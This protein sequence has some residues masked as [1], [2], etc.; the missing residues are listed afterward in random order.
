MKK[1]PANLDVKPHQ[2]LFQEDSKTSRPIFPPPASGNILALN[3]AAADAPKGVVFRKHKQQNS[4]L[5]RQQSLHKNQEIKA[6]QHNIIKNYLSQSNISNNFTSS[7]D[8][9]LNSAKK[10]KMDLFGG[11]DDDQDDETGHEFKLKKQYEGAGGQRLLELRGKWG[12]D[13]RFNIDERFKD[14]GED[15]VLP[16][17]AEKQTQMNILSDVLGTNVSLQ[18]KP[19]DHKK[20]DKSTYNSVLIDRYDPDMDTDP[21]P[22]SEET[23][24]DEPKTTVKSKPSSKKSE[25]PAEPPIRSSEPATYK[26]ASNLKSLFSSEDNN[27]SQTKDAGFSLIA[28][29]GGEID[30]H[31]EKDQVD[32]GSSSSAAGA[33][34]QFWESNPFKY[35]SSDDEDD[36]VDGTK[37]RKKKNSTVSPTEE[38]APA[39]VIP[40]CEFFF[41]AKDPRFV[42]LDSYFLKRDEMDA[43]IDYDE[44]R[45]ELRSIVKA[46]ARN[47]KRKDEKRTIAIKRAI[48]KKRKYR[49]TL[50]KSSSS[51]ATK[52]GGAATGGS[53][54]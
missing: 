21:L 52:L 25:T 29:F 42:G 39:A 14:G 37:K 31:F 50:I 10:P 19:F 15:I 48:R 46:K 3:A 27:S 5:L 41:R 12:F 4:D 7:D 45:R 24:L 17:D 30:E 11:G 20:R 35:D 53:S 13:E 38:L 1:L 40:K 36:N 9:S 32:K 44:K 33:P 6:Q 2:R 8:P 26:T 22:K 28:K 16:T 18:P 54:G 47:A 23:T 34:R 43:R 51:N 49:K